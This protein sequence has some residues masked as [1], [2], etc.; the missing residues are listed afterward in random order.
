MPQTCFRTGYALAVPPDTIGTLMSGSGVAST[1]VTR[2]F[3]IK[4]T[5]V[6]SHRHSAVDEIIALNWLLVVPPMSVC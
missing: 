4:D 3:G 2:M 1:H 6:S 5:E